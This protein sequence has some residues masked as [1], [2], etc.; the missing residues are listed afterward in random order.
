MVFGP[1]YFD[2]DVEC[3]CPLC[4]WGISFDFLVQQVCEN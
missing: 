4:Y 1:F 2:V 3:Q